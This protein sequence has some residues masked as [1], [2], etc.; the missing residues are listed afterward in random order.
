MVWVDDG[1]P[2]QE[3]DNGFYFD[4]E[5]LADETKSCG[6]TDSDYC[7]LCCLVGQFSPGSEECD[8]CDYNDECAKDSHCQPVD[9]TMIEVKRI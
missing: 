5:D 2:D 1:M 7:P 6:C 9:Q 3:P 8:W 4:D